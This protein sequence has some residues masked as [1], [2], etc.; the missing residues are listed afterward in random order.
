MGIPGLSEAATSLSTMITNGM[1]DFGKTLAG[2]FGQ[3]GAS[4]PPTNKQ[5]EAGN[6]N[7]IQTV[8][9]QSL[10]AEIAAKN[11]A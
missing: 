3:G 9:T 7:N 11:A 1:G 6:T 10:A 5:V 8:A 2:V 4:A